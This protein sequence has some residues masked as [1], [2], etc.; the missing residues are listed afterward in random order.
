LR[1]ALL[2]VSKGRPHDPR[3]NAMTISSV[4]R[5]AKVTASLLHNC[6][7]EIVEEIRRR[8]SVS[9]KVRGDTSSRTSGGTEIGKLRA[10][11]AQLASI[12]ETLLAELRAL[13]AQ[14]RD[15]S[16]SSVVSISGRKPSSSRI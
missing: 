10:K 1:K 3:N 13:R 9:P 7:P 15:G 12:N 6:Y 5:E 14:L 2:R 4:A 11:V 16:K 8:S